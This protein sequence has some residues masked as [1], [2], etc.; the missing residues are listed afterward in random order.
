MTVKLVKGKG[1]DSS[2]QK[3]ETLLK[4]TILSLGA[5]LCKSYLFPVT[6]Y[7]CS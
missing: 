1:G 5:I 7:R 2:A 6:L 3:Y 4:L